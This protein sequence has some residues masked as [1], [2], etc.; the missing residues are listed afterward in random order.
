M[1]LRRV[2]NIS[3]AVL[4]ATIAI[5][6]AVHILLGIFSEPPEVQQNKKLTEDV[7]KALDEL[8]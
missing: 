7:Q 4:L 6:I 5:A 3:G 2:L 8:Q 1:E